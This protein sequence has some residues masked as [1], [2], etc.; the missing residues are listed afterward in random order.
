MK[1]RLA[2]A[3][4]LA[5]PAAF[6]QA[7]PMIEHIEPT[8]GPPG[9]RVRI[10]GRGFQ[11]SYRVLFN[12]HPVTPVEVLPERITVVVPDGAQTGRWVLSNGTDEVETR[13]IFRVTAADP[14]PV[15]Q[16]V[17]PAA[18]APG[19]EVLLRGQNFAARPLDNTV[20]IGNLPMVVRS[21]DTTALRVI[22]PDGARTGPVFVRT[23]GGEARSPGDLTISDRLVVREFT[24]A[25]VAPGGHVT[26]RGTGFSPT[27]ASNRVTVNGRP[28]RVLRASAAELEVEVP[29]DAQGGAIAVSVQGGGRYETAQR[30]FVGAAPVIREMA[31]P[32]AAPGGRVALRG[33]QFG[34]DA[35][36]VQVTVGGRAATV[37]SAAPQ[38]VV[39]TVPE[40][41][42]TGRVAI[43]ANGIGPVESATDLT[44]LVPV[45]V[46]RFEPRSGDVGDEVTL[47]GTGFSTTANEN[48]VSLGA[49]V[50]PVMSATPTTLVVQV[51]PGARSGQWNVNVTG[52]GQA[53][54][55]DPFMITLRPRIT[56]VEPASGV[57]G[58]RVTLRGQNFPTDRA[59]VSVRLNG[60][61]VQAERYDRDAIELVVPR[62]AQTGRFEV[63]ARLQGTGRAPAD[64]VVLQPVT[65]REVSP[66]AGPLGSTV[67]LRGEGFEPDPARLHVRLGT[68]VLRPTRTS[69][70]EIVFTVPRPSRG[71]VITIEAEGRQTVTS[72][73]FA[74]TVPPVLTAVAPAQGAPGTRLTLRGRNFG[75]AVADVGVTINGVACPV[76]TV[77]P[78]AVT[79]EVAA[80]TTTGPVVLRVAN[81]GEVTWRAPFRVAAAGASPQPAR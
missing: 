13:D 47:T 77:T 53:R 32:R 38:E 26:L 64:F 18:S 43:T 25:A 31:P 50:A 2:L 62:G 24:P 17:E 59:L 29:V 46:A 73:P 9:T 19:A 61:E 79:C 3:L 36:H 76:A 6:A 57:P 51:P 74:I 45:T 22:V 69:T 4:T 34:T 60:Q 39:I 21:G 35:S 54:A 66:P 70:T 81:A 8:A 12:E 65:L 72:A 63:I 48:A 67:T 68:T 14:A 44:V 10:V 1:T 52:N 49:Q 58:A 7:R 75:S 71:G 78:T 40:G 42:Q 11:R 37:V 16:A 27:L 15:V 33:A 41:A 30:L 56:S 23:G 5:A 55:R 80:D 20:R 28:V